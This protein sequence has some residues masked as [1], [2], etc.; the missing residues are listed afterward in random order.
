MAK[1]RGP[2]AFLESKSNSRAQLADHLQLPRRRHLTVGRQT[3][4]RNRHGT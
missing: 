1:I 2:A 3:L 4:Q